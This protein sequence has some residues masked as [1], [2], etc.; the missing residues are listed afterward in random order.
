[1]AK[2]LRYTYLGLFLSML[3][4]YFCITAL[5]DG[6]IHVYVLDIGQGDAILIRSPNDEFILIDG[7]P[8]DEVIRQLGRVMPFYD[9][10]IDIAIL[11]H[12]HADHINGLI[13]VLKRY[14]VRSVMMTG[15]T[16]NSPSYRSFLEEIAK[17]RIPLV[18]AGKTGTDYRLG[19]LI[20]DMIYPFHPLQGQTFENL[21][22]GSIVLR[23][24]FGK[25][26]FYFNGDAEK[27]EEDEILRNAPKIKLDLHADFLK[28][29]H[30]GSRTSSDPA[31]LDRIQPQYA[32]ISC[33][34]DNPFH[35][36]HA[37]TLEHF[38]ERHITSFR[39]DV[40]GLIEAVSDGENLSVKSLGK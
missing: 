27:E 3:V 21:N 24:L 31:L 23:L 30:H 35:H 8:N 20:L 29:G 39:T 32:A 4:L 37:I 34:V 36:P 10:T 28:A 22:N 13:E 11:T 16:Y 7:G 18:Y 15:V 9:H 17:K 5:P 40:D 25:K 38:M 12:P 1:M 19:E 26:V 2:F 6:K 14:E 33:G